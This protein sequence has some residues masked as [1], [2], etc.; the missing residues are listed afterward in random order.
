MALGCGLSLQP[1]GEGVHSI[2]RAVKTL[3]LTKHFKPGRNILAVEAR[4]ANTGAAGLL[5]ELVATFATGA[6][7]RVATSKVWQSRKTP[8]A[9][10]QKAH[11]VGKYGVSPWDHVGSKRGGRR[12]GAKHASSKYKAGHLREI[13]DQRPL[14]SEA[15]NS[16]LEEDWL[17]Q[18]DNNPTAARTTQEIGWARDLAARILAMPQAPD[19]TAE[20]AALDKLE[21]GAPGSFDLEALYLDVRRG[22]RKIA[23]RNPLIDFDEDGAPRGSRCCATKAGFGARERVRR[24]CI[25]GLRL[26][27]PPLRNGIRSI[28]FTQ[29]KRAETQCGGDLPAWRIAS[30]FESFLSARVCRGSTPPTH[31]LCVE[32]PAKGVVFNVR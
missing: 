7:M 14:D 31:D 6:P 19:L 9:E 24:Q 32:I 29:C 1:R 22:K 17:F 26:R 8:D 28:S 5:G 23:F 16:L 18:A 10:W 11:V 20:L 27:I 4:N 13:A 25:R 30:I 21:A 2:S 15:A 12:K 3:D